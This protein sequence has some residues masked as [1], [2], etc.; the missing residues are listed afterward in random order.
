MTSIFSMAATKI[1][2]ASNFFL[3]A[4]RILYSLKKVLHVT[5]NVCLHNVVLDT[6]KLDFFRFSGY[7]FS[8][9][10]E[11]SIPFAWHIYICL[12]ER[13]II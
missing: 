3:T 8:K 11:I 6:Q 10:L 2:V 1:E 7:L 5:F 12:D 4:N 13:R 9:T